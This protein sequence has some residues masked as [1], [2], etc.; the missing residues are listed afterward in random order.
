M[1]HFWSSDYTLDDQTQKN[2]E[3]T[4][5]WKKVSVWSMFS[6]K[7]NAPEKNILPREPFLKLTSW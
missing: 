4:H 6:S 2:I 3:Q 1:V 7:N 5:P